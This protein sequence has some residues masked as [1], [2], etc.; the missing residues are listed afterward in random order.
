[1][2]QWIKSRLDNLNHTSPT[3]DNILRLLAT[4]FAG[5]VV[6]AVCL[7]GT[8]WAWFSASV[9][10]PLQKT[11]AANYEIAVSILDGSG[12]KPVETAKGS[13]SLSENVAYHVTLKAQGTAN[14]FGGYCAIGLED[15]DEPLFHTCQIKPGGAL[16]FTMI[17]DTT[18]VYT[19]TAVWGEYSGTADK[20]ENGAVVGQKQ[21][22][23]SA[24][25]S[26]PPAGEPATD[27]SG[28]VGTDAGQQGEEDATVP[29]ADSA[30]SEGT[31]SA[32]P[33][34]TESQPEVEEPVRTESES[35][36]TEPTAKNEIPGGIATGL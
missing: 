25:L 10:A 26:V 20:L 13:Y 12:G 22:D 35:T 14:E 5:L 28:S 4:S 29:P 9:Q 19:F 36:S 23:N 27:G 32:N 2:K 6:C 33:P 18:D 24:E 21:P 30:P 15:A 11:A 3:D 8:T 7:A 1:M 17:P 31:A 34:A 16:T